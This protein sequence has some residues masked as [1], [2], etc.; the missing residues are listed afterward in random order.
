M[1]KREVAPPI[2]S[3]VSQQNTKHINS[4]LIF[5]AVRKSGKAARVKI[6]EMTGL[7]TSTVSELVDGLITDGLLVEYGNEVNQSRG[8]NPILLSINPEGGYTIVI[9]VINTGYN[10]YLCNLLCEIV[11]TSFYR[12]SEGKKHCVGEIIEGLLGANGIK[13]ES[14]LGICIDYPGI[15]DRRG[16][17]MLYSIVV[18]NED[19]LNNED[20]DLLA[21]RFP[22]AAMMVNNDSS[23]AAY[24]S[25]RVSGP[26]ISEV[27]IYLNMFECVGAGAILSNGQ[28]EDIYEFPIEIGQLL[29]PAGDESQAGE[30][31]TFEK[32]TNAL[33]IFKKI[34]NQ[35]DIRLDYTD[36]YLTEKNFDCMK[37]IGDELAKGNTEV[38]SVISDIAKDIAIA[39]SNIRNTIQPSDVFVG[40]MVKN[41]GEKFVEMIEKEISLIPSLPYDGKMNIHLSGIDN[42][43]KIVGAAN[44]LMDSVFALV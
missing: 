2:R 4:M 28:G 5:D 11:G 12:V 38:E 1:K 3:G 42:S 33:E 23:I 15:C 10:C 25:F 26:H 31:E 13:N 40:G 24:A 17:S 29:M 41:L 37:T 27:V 43:T 34:N 21:E 44:M 39:L 35:T 32:R 18:D 22:N 9:E 20:I 16:R 7:S 30:L 14:V 19:Y 36:E 6:S 8:R